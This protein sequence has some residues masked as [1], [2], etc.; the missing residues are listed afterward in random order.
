MP[1]RCGGLE[2]L[3]EAFFLTFWPKNGPQPHIS[4]RLSRMFQQKNNQKVVCNALVAWP[5]SPPILSIFL[6]RICYQS[7]I[8]LTVG[9]TRTRPVFRVHQDNNNRYVLCWIWCQQKGVKDGGSSFASPGVVASKLP[10]AEPD[11][12]VNARAPPELLPTPAITHSKH[13]HR[14]NP[15]PGLLWVGG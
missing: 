4:P 9:C 12:W 13:Y 11:A 5:P 8:I 2:T 15:R 10:S 1:V 14:F 3:F 6:E 7:Q